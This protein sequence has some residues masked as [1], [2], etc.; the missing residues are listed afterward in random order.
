MYLF[1]E[2]NKLGTTIVIATHDNN[3]VEKIGAPRLHLEGGKLL[4]LEGTKKN[5]GLNLDKDAGQS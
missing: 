1:V 2:L 4:H 3:L 5:I